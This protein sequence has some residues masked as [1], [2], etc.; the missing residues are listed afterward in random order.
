MLEMKIT[1][2]IT[3]SMYNMH[4]LVRMKPWQYEDLSV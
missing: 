3:F 4:V 1:L 2:T